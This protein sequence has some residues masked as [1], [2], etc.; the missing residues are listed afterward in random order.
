MLRRHI[1][2]NLLGFGCFISK[3]CREVELDETLSLVEK[4]K[5]G[6]SEINGSVVAVLIINALCH[7]GLMEDA[8]RAL[9]EL[10][11]RGCKP[12]FIAYRIVSE[13]FRLA[14]RVEDAGRILKQKRKLGVA[15]RVKDYGE[16][17]LL[18]VSERRV[19]EAKELGEVI[20]DGDF[21]MDDDVLNALIGSVS[22][23]DPD[24]S[25][26]FCKYMLGKER[27]PRLAIL[28]NLSRSLCKNGKSD[29]MWDIFR[30]LLD[31]GYFAEVEQYNVMVS[32]LCKAGRVREAYDVLKEMK[33]NGLRPDISSYNTLMEACCREDLLR[34]AK[35]LWDE[36]FA[37][38]YIPNLQTYNILIK[39]FSEEDE[40]EEAHKLFLHMLDKGVVPD[41]VT[42][43]SLIEVMCREKRIEAALEIF[44]KSV[45][46]DALASGSILSTLIFL[47]CKDGNFIAACGVMHDFPSTVEN[48][49]SHVILLKSL[50][51]AGEVGMS[52]K[53]V[54]WVNTNF[55][56]KL[57]AIL[58]E[59]IAFVST[60]PALGPVTQ[61]LQAVHARGF[62]VDN[63]L[64]M[65]L[66]EGQYKH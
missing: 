51:D 49:D 34:P 1:P 17:I 4:V 26:S 27:F 42:Y 39:K 55:A 12:D 37:N 23:I 3:L 31:K 66:L 59:F 15:P 60:A 14:G 21:P 54:E 9:E 56:S 53:H 32:F 41:N 11:V 36:M 57:P 45:E 30:T 28:S 8:W 10:R 2:L 33:K 24:A 6:H 16:F 46:Q 64:L 20:V 62:L 50:I 40:A 61:F 44:K 29:E 65:N 63:V 58:M 48:S 38:G 47:L 52:I 13:A 18:L 43:M 7:A 25:V 22:V 35:K 5:K 19:H